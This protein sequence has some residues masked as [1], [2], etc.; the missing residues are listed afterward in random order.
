[1]A[2]PSPEPP[3]KPDEAGELR[4]LPIDPDVDGA[5][6][7][8]VRRGRLRWPRIHWTSVAAVGVGGF[9]GGIAR[10]GV[11]QAWPTAAGG[12]PWDVFGVNT[13]GALLLGLLLVLVAEVLPP[14]TYLRPALGTGFCGAFTTF[15]SV[16]VGFDRL[17][18]HGHA[19]LAVGYLAASVFGGLAAAAFGMILGRS[20]AA[21]RRKGRR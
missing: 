17:A 18:A 19:A 5:N 8:A 16:T 12:F 15:S 2:Q 21:S 13:A 14:S 7:R 9:L 1:M 3:R 20:I 6:A 11:G 10:Y 4:G